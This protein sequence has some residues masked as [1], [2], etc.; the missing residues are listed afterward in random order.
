MI[1]KTALFLSVF[2]C[3][4]FNIDAEESILS[5]SIFPIRLQNNVYNIC[6]SFPGGLLFKFTGKREKLSGNKIT[7]ELDLPEPIEYLISCGYMPSRENTFA[8]FI[9]DEF[10]SSKKECDGKVYNHYEIT[11]NSAICDRIGP[12]K[13]W[14]NFDR[15]YL[16]APANSRGFS[17]NAYWEFKVGNNSC[18]KGTF[19]VKVLPPVE[20][21]AKKCSRFGL[22]VSRLANLTV[23]LKEVSDAYLNY[24]KSLQV[25]PLTFDLPRYTRY[26][27]E[28]LIK[29]SDNFDM[30]YLEAGCNRGGMPHFLF[31]RK[32]YG[33]L[34]PPL[35]DYKGKE[36]KS[37]FDFK[38][39]LI[40]PWYLIEDPDGIIWEKE[41]SRFAAKIKNS[42]IKIKAVIWDFEPHAVD[43]G[44]SEKNKEYFKNFA[45]LD[46]IP[47]N[48][49]IIKKYTK[50]WFSFRLGQNIS[51]VKRFSSA[52]R[53]HLPRVEFIL[54]SDNLHAGWKSPVAE[55]CGVDVRLLDEDID[56]HMHMPYYSGLQ[57]YNDL[58]FNLEALKKPYFPLID[59]AEDN[60]Y[61]YSK[62]TPEKVKQNIMAT[63]ALGCAG[64]G[65]WPEDI[66]DGRY[67]LK[68]ASAYGLI[69][70]VEDFYL[71][72]PSK[73][74][75]YKWEP[76]N[77]LK[78]DC[79]SNDGTG[80]E[81]QI[82]NFKDTVKVVMHEDKGIFLATIF[83]Y[84]TNPAIIKFSFSEITNPYC[85]VKDIQSAEIFTEKT[86]NISRKT[87]ND[88]FLIEI[89]PSEVKVLEISPINTGEVPANKTAPQEF[90]KEKLRA[91]LSQIGLKS[92][93]YRNKEDIAS[94]IEWVSIKSGAAYVPFLKVSM[95]ERDL[96]ID[97]RKGFDITGWKKKN[98]KQTIYYSPSAVGAVLWDGSYY[99]TVSRS[100]RHTSLNSKK[101]LLKTAIRNSF[102]NTAF[103]HIPVPIP[104]QILLKVWK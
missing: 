46:H 54:A 76:M 58:I 57:Y 99:M 15:L 56:M 68:I 66:L 71:K 90:L 52:M 85:V 79:K 69:S 100:P 74:I 84:D 30:A 16:K 45:K 11:V 18:C 75:A 62:Y 48:E 60:E 70:K 93:I 40:S 27:P 50:E 20:F 87:I 4:V 67:L 47:S 89:A 39:G 49:E 14:N 51:I 25:R 97:S 95:S 23:P 24:W 31:T 43:E 91:S 44:F 77:I 32:D 65:F 59:P 28:T 29:I 9:S 42:P 101:H 55:W 10:I 8:E 5:P 13:A 12:R 6:E 63:A 3:T 102:S 73:A 38:A 94:E 98:L 53:K 33:C 81:L 2:C 72:K 64:I 41:F 80:I 78:K 96:L 83:N 21:P 88:G 26:S 35:I 17:G 34:L 86:E 22:A 82:P 36:V 103:L 7:L 37:G 1:R 61:F 104:H 19:I 92:D